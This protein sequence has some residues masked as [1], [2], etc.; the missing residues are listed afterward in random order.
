[1]RS[2]WLLAGIKV[3]LSVSTP[4]PCSAEPLVAECLIA[5]WH[6]AMPNAD[7][8]LDMIKWRRTFLQAL[9]AVT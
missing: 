8:Q 9:D 5:F 1:M 3:W 7:V 2:H 6:A 4:I